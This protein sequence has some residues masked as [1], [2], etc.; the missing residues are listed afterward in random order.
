[1]VNSYFYDP[2]FRH[3]QVV[4]PDVLRY[5]T[6]VPLVSYKMCNLGNCGN[7]GFGWQAKD[8]K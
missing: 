7:C 6:H 1:M 4:N 2:I 5:F 3:R 8:S